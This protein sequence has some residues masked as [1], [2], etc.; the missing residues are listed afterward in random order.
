MTELSLPLMAHSL[1]SRITFKGLHNSPTLPP[2]PHRRT[3]GTQ[4]HSLESV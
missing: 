3:E 4:H 1:L 2:P